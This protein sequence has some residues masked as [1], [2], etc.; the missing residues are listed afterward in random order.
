MLIIVL[1]Q[2]LTTVEDQIPG[3]ES[4]K[5]MQVDPPPAAAS[6]LPTFIGFN[7]LGG[8]VRLSPAAVLQAIPR[9]KVVQD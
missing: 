6:I 2:S 3:K 1:K 5:A 7:L 8:A 4:E 9:P